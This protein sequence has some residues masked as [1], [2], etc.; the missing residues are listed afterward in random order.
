[1]GDAVDQFGAAAGRHRL[2]ERMKCRLVEALA[3]HQDYQRAGVAEYVIRAFD[4]SEICWF[5][6]DQGTL[7]QRTPGDDG[8]YH[9][10]VFPGLWLD[11]AALLT[12][13]T[14]RL[15]AVVD[16]GCATAAHAA[17]VARLA[18]SRDRR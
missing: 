12:G 3:F 15:R 5:G 13:D 18:D 8:L 10:T 17:F 1:M 16:L 11:P 7:V 2:V 14:Q 4:P 9:S 6:L